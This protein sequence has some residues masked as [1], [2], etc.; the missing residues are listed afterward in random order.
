MI[1]IYFILSIF[2]M[3][4]FMYLSRWSGWKKDIGKQIDNYKQLRRQLPDANENNLASR[5]LRIKI[6]NDLNPSLK[7]HYE[8]L[9]SQSGL[10]L[11]NTLFFII[12][13]D[14]IRGRGL[15]PV[16]SGPMLFLNKVKD[17][18][19]DTVRKEFPKGA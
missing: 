9:S 15:N 10:T 4:I 5:L 8:T 2:V 18:I 7:K 1:V 11:R 6:K 19:D 16:E 12:E 13:Y 14:Y 3:G 17:H